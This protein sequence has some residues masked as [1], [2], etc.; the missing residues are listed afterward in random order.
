[1]APTL[2]FD[3]DESDGLLLAPVGFAVEML[4][5]DT[6]LVTMEDVVLG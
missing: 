5:V 3:E 4:D 6:V 2:D 1:M